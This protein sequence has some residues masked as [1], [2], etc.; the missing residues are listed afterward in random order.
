MYRYLQTASA[1]S[2]KLL[3][4][5]NTRE[6]YTTFVTRGVLR[7]SSRYQATACPSFYSFIIN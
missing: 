1:S 4:A 3:S 6:F 5:W 7:S 2:V